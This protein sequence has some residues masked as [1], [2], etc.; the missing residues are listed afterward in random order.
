MSERHPRKYLSQ[1]K[2]VQLSVWLNNKKDH[3]RSLNGTTAKHIGEIASKDL[4]FEVTENNI[5]MM[6]QNMP[7]LDL[8]L[9]F[10]TTPP[11]GIAIGRVTKLH[12]AVLG[13]FE[14]CG[15]KAPD[16]ITINW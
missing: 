12:K 8:N 3:I 11:F 13:L 6:L 10:K 15:E 9:T 4:G 1:A 2:C 16:D 7:D 14:K 5:K